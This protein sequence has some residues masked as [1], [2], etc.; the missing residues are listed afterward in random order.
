MKILG[1]LAYLISTFL[2]YEIGNVLNISW[3]MLHTTS[4]YPNGSIS[5]VSESVLPFLL[6]LPIYSLT[7]KKLKTRGI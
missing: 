3:L 6:S 4:Y 7:V 1:T 5:Q 2:F